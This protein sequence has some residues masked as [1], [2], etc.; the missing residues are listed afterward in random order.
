MALTASTDLLIS[1][2]SGS[3]GIKALIET[4]LDILNEQIIQPMEY[5]ESQRRI[6]DAEGVWLHRIGE[7]LG[8]GVPSVINRTPDDLFGFAVN[9]VGFDQGR[10]N[11]PDII[12]TRETI[13]DI[14]YRTFL[15]ARA[16]TLLSHGDLPAFEEA[17]HMID[18]NA[19]VTDNHDMSFRVKSSLLEIIELADNY[20][21]LP[22]PAGVRMILTDVNFFGF[23]SGDVGFDLGSMFDG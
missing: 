10:I 17:I 1:Q 3:P 16:V 21:V 13:S 19:V 22:R 6:D 12:L 15:K 11:D 4:W 8:L 9:N 5:L 20:R 14:L 18:P 23:A 2:W 7:R